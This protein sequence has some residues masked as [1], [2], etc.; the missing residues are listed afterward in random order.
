[1]SAS[2]RSGYEVMGRSN[3]F[4]ATMRLSLVAASSASCASNSSSRT[5]PSCRSMVGTPGPSFFSFA[6]NSLVEVE[7]STTC[8][9]VI[10]VNVSLVSSRSS[11]MARASF[12][13][14]L[15]PSRASSAAAVCSLASGRW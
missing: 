13:R 4:S 11:S 6:R 5:R 15:Q 3:S 1:M 7:N 12:S 9:F 10:S 2:T 14:T 8:S